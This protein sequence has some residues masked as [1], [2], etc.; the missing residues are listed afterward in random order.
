MTL[1]KQGVP[2]AYEPQMVDIARSA[3]DALDAGASP[4]QLALTTYSKFNDGAGRKAITLE[5][6]G[7]FVGASVGAF[8]PRHLDAVNGD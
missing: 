2:L 1:S 5:Q 4:Q 8:C 3:C 7:V 6:A